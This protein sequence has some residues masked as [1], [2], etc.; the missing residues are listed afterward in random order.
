M[1]KYDFEVRKADC[2]PDAEKDEATI[3]IATKDGDTVRLKIDGLG[4]LN[5]LEEI[6]RSV[7]YENAKNSWHSPETDEPPSFWLR[8]RRTLKLA[9]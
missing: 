7:G 6:N 8:A 5:L 9:S 2:E 1:T 3:A 4:L